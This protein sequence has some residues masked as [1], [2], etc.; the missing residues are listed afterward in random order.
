MKRSKI[1]LGVTTFFLAAV[2]FTS[3]KH[4]YLRAVCYTTAV[5]HTQIKVQDQPCSINNPGSLPQCVIQGRL[6]WTTEN[7]LVPVFS[8]T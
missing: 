1:F 7:C 2:A 6:C 8:A 4:K 3:A 5:G